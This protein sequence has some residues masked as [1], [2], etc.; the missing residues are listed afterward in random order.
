VSARLKEVK[1][2]LPNFVACHVRFQSIS[3][4]RTHGLAHRLLRN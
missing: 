1:E 2:A 4:H 3:G